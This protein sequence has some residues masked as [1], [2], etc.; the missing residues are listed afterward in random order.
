[1]NNY[2]NPGHVKTQKMAQDSEKVVQEVSYMDM[3]K[4]QGCVIHDEESGIIYKE[5]QGWLTRSQDNC[6]NPCYYRQIIGTW[7]RGILHGKRIEFQMNLQVFP[8][9]YYAGSFRSNHVKSL[10]I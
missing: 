9:G 8:E 2:I 4:F 3:S 1:M 10:S 7:S 5:G 6:I